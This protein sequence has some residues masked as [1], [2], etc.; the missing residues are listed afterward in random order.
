MNIAPVRDA[1][2]E[3]THFIATK[4]DVTERKSLEEQLQQAAKMEAVGRLA[5]GVAHDFNNLLTIINGY[6]ELLLEKFASDNKVSVHL[7][8]VKEAGERA[9]SLTRQLLAFSRR[10]VLAPQVLDLNAV[11]SNLAATNQPST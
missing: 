1:R 8:E 7:K 5:G 11:V 9:A 4:Q 10:Q 6:T 3:V 2:G